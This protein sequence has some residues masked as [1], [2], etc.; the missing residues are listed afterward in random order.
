[1]PANPRHRVCTF[2]GV[3]MY[4]YRHVY[5]PNLS[6]YP[7]L[8]INSVGVGHD[9][10]YWAKNKDVATVGRTAGGGEGARG[11]SQMRL[12]YPSL[13]LRPLLTFRTSDVQN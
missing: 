3:S 2:I 10:H 5:T 8:L 6:T 4:V 11:E 7:H 9:A 12:R 13:Q 1:M